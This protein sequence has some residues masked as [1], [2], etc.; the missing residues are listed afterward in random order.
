MTFDFTIHQTLEFSFIISF[1]NF[2][3][4]FTYPQN[5]LKFLVS[6]IRKRPFGLSSCQAINWQIFLHFTSSCN[7]LGVVHKLCKNTFLL[8]FVFLEE[9]VNSSSRQHVQN[10]LP[11]SSNV[12]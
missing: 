10:V 7:V 1:I 6:T 12:T 8:F 9:L 4:T 3:I 5:F 11:L 2:H